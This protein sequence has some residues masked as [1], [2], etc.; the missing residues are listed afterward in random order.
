MSQAVQLAKMIALAATKHEGQ[1]D[2]GGMPYI[3]HVMKVM[4][5]LRTEDLELMQMAVGHD[6]IEDTDVT[7]AELRAMGTSER[8]IDGIRRLTKVPGQT[9]EE[10]KNGIK[11][12]YDAIRV[13]MADLRHNSDIR[14]LKGV[15]EKDLKRI[16]K[17]HKMWLEFKEELETNEEFRRKMVA[18]TTG[19]ADDPDMELFR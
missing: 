9:A 6:L 5:Y 18:S 11:E 1:L 7:Y 15:T 3:L 12:S 8:V 16:E 4:H 2:R 19:F 10:Y 13:K 17:Y 14:R